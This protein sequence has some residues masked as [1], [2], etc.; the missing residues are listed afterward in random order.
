MRK[1][2]VVLEVPVDAWE[3]LKET[4]ELDTQSAAFDKDL[5]KKISEALSEVKEHTKPNVYLTAYLD[6]SG[7]LQFHGGL[8]KGDWEEM[9]GRD[10]QHCK[11]LR[12]FYIAGKILDEDGLEEPIRVRD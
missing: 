8:D 11:R 7:D 6:G 1:K 5:R 3:T 12:C 10:A 4:L 9:L 2:T